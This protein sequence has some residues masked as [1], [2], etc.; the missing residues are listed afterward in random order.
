MPSQQAGLSATTGISQANFARAVW[1]VLPD[2]TRYRGAAAVNAV[3]GIALNTRWPLWI[4]RLPIMRQVQD[5][6]YWLVARY[7][8][9]LPG[10]T[11]HCEQFP[12]D[13]ESTNESTN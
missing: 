2:G 12:E 8:R 6:V 7:R 13:C 9:Y 10:V 5:G 3:L 4:Y 11:P 1:L